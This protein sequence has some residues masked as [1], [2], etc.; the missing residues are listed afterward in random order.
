MYVFVCVLGGGVTVGEGKRVIE[1]FKLVQN[2][3]KRIRLMS[4]I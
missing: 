1:E 4:G 2:P 3:D